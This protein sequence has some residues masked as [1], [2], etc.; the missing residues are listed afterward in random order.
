MKN[1]TVSV[2]EETHRLARIRAAE[3]DTSVSGPGAELPE[4]PGE[5]IERRPHVHIARRGN[6]GRTP[7][8]EVARGHCGHSRHLEWLQSRRQP[9]PRGTV[10]PGQSQG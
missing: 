7:A 10:R 3:L 9:A 6:R 2:D 5:R 8:E 1:I 4:E